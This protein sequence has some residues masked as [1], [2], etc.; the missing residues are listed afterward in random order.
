LEPNRDETKLPIPL[1]EVSRAILDLAAQKDLGAL[2]SR[3][4]ELVRNWGAPTAILAAAEDAG[5]ESGWRLLPALC[6]GTGPLGAERVIARL[7][8]ETPEC[9]QRPLLVKPAEDAAGVRVRDNWIV[10]WSHE[11]DSGVLVLRG[12][13]PGGPPNVGEAVLAAAAALWPR[14][15]GTPA[16]RMQELIEDLGAAA[17]RLQAESVRQ[18]DRLRQARHLPSDERAE[19]EARLAAAQEQ[20][21]T[22]VQAHE[23]ARAR[24]AEL[25]ASLGE[26]DRRRSQAESER[27]EAR[28]ELAR[29]AARLAGLEQ[30]AGSAQAAAARLSEAEAERDQA[31][32]EAQRLSER[33]AELERAASAA[34]RRAEE[35]D[36]AK[37]AAQVSSSSAHQELAAKAAALDAALSELR[38]AAFV[39]EPL[40][41]SLLRAP[42]AT[43]AHSSAPWLS[44]VLLDRDAPP[45]TALVHALEAAGVRARLAREPEELGLLVRDASAADLDVAI[46][47]I[48]AF[49]P[50]QNVAGLIRGWEK[51]RPGLAFYLSRGADPAEVDKARRVPQSLL[52]GHVQRPIQSAALLETL[53]LLAR[54]LGRQVR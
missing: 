50:D 35:A 13:A 29:A 10:P 18:L 32:A 21:E 2:A 7:V 9:R 28:A 47:D 36:Q 34:A 26:A 52:A 8:T 14:L 12:V 20:L 53:Q 48:A 16:D 15:L 54:K 24:I 27:E 19:L 42:G 23:S 40:R 22:G 49:R 41:S 45:P 39:S 46:C 3:F 37:A 11:G 17:A 30:A 38:R 1:D 25:E 33:V 43:S 44:V 6:A 5:S 31:R 51:D 4:L